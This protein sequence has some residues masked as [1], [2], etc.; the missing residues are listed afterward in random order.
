MNYYYPVQQDV[1][2]GH[3]HHVQPG[4]GYPPQVMAN[5]YLVPPAVFNEIRTAYITGFPMDTTEREVR[6]MLCFFH[7]FE[8]WAPQ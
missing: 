7:G 6:N 4:Y 5:Q 3:F 1:H 8:V 2:Q